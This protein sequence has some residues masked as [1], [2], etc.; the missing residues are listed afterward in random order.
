MNQAKLLAPFLLT[1]L[2]LTL[3]LATAGCGG[4]DSSVCDP[5][6]QSGCDDGLVCENVENDGTPLCATPLVVQ[7]RVFDLADDGAVA[8]ARLVLLDPNSAPLGAVAVSGADGHYELRVPTTRHADGTPIAQQVTLR[9]DAATYQSFPS[10]VR[11]ALPIDTGSATETDGKLVVASALTDVGLLALPAGAGTAS[12]A[13]NVEVP[14][15]HGGVLVV[16]ENGQTGYSAIAD[17][18]GDYV[19]YNLPAGDYQVAAYAL[20]SSW[21]PASVTVAAGA[22]GHADLALDDRALGRVDGTVQIVNGGGASTTSVLLVVESTF[23]DALGRGATPPG[24][25][26]GNVDGAYHLDG[27]PAGHY[28]VLAAFENDGLVRDP[29]TSIGGTATLHIEVTSGQPTTVDGFKI[30]GALGVVGPGAD[31]PEGVTATPTLRWEDDSSE[32]EYAVVVLDSL[33]QTVW[34]KSVPG[35]SGGNPELVYAGPALEVGMY[36]QFRVTSLKSGVPLARTE[37]LRGVFFV[38]P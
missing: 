28:V 26:V 9:A 3:P 20:G 5:A 11:T 23:E 33:G 19:L 34:E 2:T 29:D 21:A 27:V 18:D 12:I 15:S 37:D 16:A 7:G 36:Y 35:V 25:R 32:D 6:A 4:D 30:T 10:G 8:G 22:E 14:A 31:A 38:A 17:A 13:G 1:A 24:L